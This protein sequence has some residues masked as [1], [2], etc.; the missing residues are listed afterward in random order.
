M[1]KACIFDL[2]GTLLDTLTSI[3]H[4]LNITLKKHG[5]KEI[6]REQARIFVG[7]GAKKLVERALFASFESG[8]ADLRGNL[9]Q[10]TEEYV[11]LYDEN[12]THLTDAY[13]GIK[14]AVDGLLSAGVKLAV[15]SNKPDS[16]VKL[17]MEHVFGNKFLISEG[18][19]EGVPLKPAPEAPL[20][21]CE[22]LG[23]LPSEV[24]YFG[25]TSVDMQTGKNFGAGMTV[26]VLWGFRDR[27]ELEQ[28]GADVIISSPSEIVAT[29]KEF[30]DF[31]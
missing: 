29:V 30:S 28:G 2:D 26:G 13:S 5:A 9:A 19:R 12:P 23:V 15:L 25:D 3:Q 21:L 14:E 10:I 4:F 24:A 22:R 27:A 20:S 7:E 16:T 11:G 17:L 31:A 18:G 1:I 8:C 6:T